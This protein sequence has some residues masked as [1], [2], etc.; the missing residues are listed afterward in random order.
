MIDLTMPVTATVLAL[1][2]ADPP[3]PADPTSAKIAAISAISVALIGG[4]VALLTAW[5]GKRTTASTPP[6]AASPDSMRAAAEL[7]EALLV[8]ERQEGDALVK[9]LNKSRKQVASLS[10]SL[11]HARAAES[12][13]EAALDALRQEMVAVQA[14]AALTANKLAEC[15]T[16]CSEL[17]TRLALSATDTA[18]E[19]TA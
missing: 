12:A 5:I 19:G 6:P 1:I 15:Q 2:T 11:N 3:K 13:S 14:Q 4:A 10:N 17:T 16:R 8:R 7:L 18:P 9:E